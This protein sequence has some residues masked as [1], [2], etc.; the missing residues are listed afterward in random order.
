MIRPPIALCS[1]GGPGLRSAFVDSAHGRITPAPSDEEAVAI[2]AAVDALWPRPVAITEPLHP[3]ST[4][5][6]FS[7][8]W[9]HRDRMANPDRPWR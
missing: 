6:R 8:R 2:A 4:T 1:A 3:T 5:W 7:G 9:W